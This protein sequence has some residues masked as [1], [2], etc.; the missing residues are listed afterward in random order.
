MTHTKFHLLLF[1]LV[2]ASLLALSSC[3]PSPQKAE[4]YFERM[5]DC[6]QAVLETEDALIQLIN[7]EMQ[8]TLIDSVSANLPQNSDTSGYAAEINVAYDDFCMQ[9]KKSQAQLRDIGRF[10]NKTELLDAATSLL[11]TYRSLSAKEYKEVV[12]IVKIPS[13]LYTNENDNRFLDLTE[14]ID[15]TLQAQI[16]NFTRA[17]K[18]FARDYNFEISLDDSTFFNE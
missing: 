13:S 6:Q 7:I 10:N 3:K 8:K 2:S 12:E 5:M 17:S 15:T 14:H 16:D 1:F 4:E 9:I 18:A 11:E